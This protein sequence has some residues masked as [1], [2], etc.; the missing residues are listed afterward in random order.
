MQCLRCRFPL[1]EGAAACPDCGFSLA[2]LDRRFGVVPRHIQEITD[3]A[4]L[5]SSR[6]R[7]RLARKLHLLHGRFP[8]VRLSVF[9]CTAPNRPSREYGFWVFNRCRFH[10]VGHRLGQCRSLLLLF[11]RADES[12]SLTCG[13]GLESVLHETEVAAILEAGAAEWSRQRYEEG[14]LEVL[15]ALTVALAT[16]GRKR[17]RGERAATA[18]RTR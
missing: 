3:G 15:E 13:Y 5:F 9:S 7:A 12:V 10:Q 1:D 2:E 18:G 8:E 14:A 11:N 6:G 17:L 16:A 4:G